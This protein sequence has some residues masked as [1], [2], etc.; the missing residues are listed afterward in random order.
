MKVI[1]KS[2]KIKVLIV[3]NMTDLTTI[4]DKNWKVEIYTGRYIH[5]TY[6]Y[7]ETIGDT[8]NLTSSSNISHS[9]GNSNNN[10]TSSLQPIIATLRDRQNIIFECR[11]IIG[12]K[13]D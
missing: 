11:V 7:L 8:T 1:P 2:D 12:H 9:F 13:S 10:A 4:L 6:H 5:D 3:P